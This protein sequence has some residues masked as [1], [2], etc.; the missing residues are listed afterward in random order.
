MAAFSEAKDRSYCFKNI[1]APQIDKK[2]LFCLNYTA[3]F[4]KHLT[5]TLVFEK[6][7][8]LFRR[9]LAKIAEN[10]DQKTSTTVCKTDAFECPP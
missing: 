7:A 6:N 1:F 8:N 4:S 5:L 10:C 9:K 2:W 3:S